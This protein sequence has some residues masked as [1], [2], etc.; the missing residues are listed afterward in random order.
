[1]FS[2]FDHQ[3]FATTVDC[4]EPKLFDCSPSFLT[5]A[6]FDMVKSGSAG[7][8]RPYGRKVSAEELSPATKGLFEK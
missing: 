2:H 5:L 6:T 3:T 1:M 8:V 7:L 4:A